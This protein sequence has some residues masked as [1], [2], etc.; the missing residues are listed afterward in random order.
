M[1]NSMTKDLSGLS[2][3]WLRHFLASRTSVRKSLS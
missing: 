3:A 2:S 1:I